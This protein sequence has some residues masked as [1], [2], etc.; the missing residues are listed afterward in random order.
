MSKSETTDL[1]PPRDTPPMSAVDALH[2]VDVMISLMTG[3]TGKGQ[4]AQ[5]MRGWGR[6]MEDIRPYV[7]KAAARSNQ[8]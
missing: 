6:W 2:R 3:W 1:L 4:Q 7:A 8:T 5:L